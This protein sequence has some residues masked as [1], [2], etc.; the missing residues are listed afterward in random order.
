MRE[1]YATIK[2]K[3]DNNPYRESCKNFTENNPLSQDEQVTIGH[4]Y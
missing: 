4:K 3:Y 2:N 1:E